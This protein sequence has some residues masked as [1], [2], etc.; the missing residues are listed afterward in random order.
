MNPLR[1]AFL[2]GTGIGLFVGFVAGATA[3]AGFFG[4]ARHVLLRRSEA[5]LASGR[6]PRGEVPEPRLSPPSTVQR[7]DFSVP[8]ERTGGMPGDLRGLRGK[9]VVLNLWATWCAPCI[10][11]L[12]DL[13]A[14]RG[15]FK[16]DTRIAFVGISKDTRE[17][18][19]AYLERGQHE[20]PLLRL[21]DGASVAAAGDMVP[22]TLVIDA[23]ENVVAVERG[24]MKWNSDR[25]Y[26]YLHAL[27]ANVK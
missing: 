16:D 27:L 5:R 15:R 8:V 21:G 4:Y 6:Y 3:L 11:E 19:Q 23:T 7:F 1:R 2:A 17:A 24:A 20:M 10:A 9:V 18:F 25:A 22:V 14:L 26:Q 12:S 13:E